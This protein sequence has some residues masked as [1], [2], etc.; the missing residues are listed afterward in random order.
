ME[1]I[2]RTIDDSGLAVNQTRDPD[3]VMGFTS[4]ISN[5]HP[6]EDT[7]HPP[8]IEGTDENLGGA[9]MMDNGFV[10]YPVD[11]IFS[12]FYTAV[13]SITSITSNTE[14]Y[15]QYAPYVAGAIIL[16]LILKR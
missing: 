16:L 5:I 6:A 15:M 14:T 13:E 9:T 1:T 12:P 7:A 11:Q 10:S 8:T 4:L 2:A 3:A